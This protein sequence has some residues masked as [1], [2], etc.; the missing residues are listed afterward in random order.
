MGLSIGL[1]GISTKKGLLINMDSHSHNF[2]HYS[3]KY[4]MIIMIILDHIPYYNDYKIFPIDH[5]FINGIII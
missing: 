3:D 2:P 4:Q 5:I 1:L